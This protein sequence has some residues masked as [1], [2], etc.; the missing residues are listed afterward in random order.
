MKIILRV[1]LFAFLLFSLLLLSKPFLLTNYQ[2]FSY[3]YYAAQASVHHINP[4]APGGLYSG[5]LYPPVCLI[6]LIPF[7]VFPIEIAAKIWTILGIILL[8]ASVSLLLKILGQKVNSNFSIFV[9]SLAFLYFPSRYTL[10]MGQIN[11]FILFFVTIA[12]YF[13][14][15]NKG[16]LSGFFL[17]LSLTIKYFP[18]FILPY[19]FFRKKWRILISL[20]LTLVILTIFGLLFIDQKTNIYFFTKTFPGLLDSNSSTYYYNQALSGFLAREIHD[21]SLRSVSKIVISFIVLIS[22]FFVFYKNKN[23]KMEYILFEIG[24]IVNIS[25]LLNSFSWQH[26]YIWL[27]IPLIMTTIFIKEHKLSYW[28]YVIL[29]VVFLLTS[30]NINNPRNVPLI[31]QSHAFY[32]GIVLLLFDLYILNKI[33]LQKKSKN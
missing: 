12:L 16:N 24:I 15:R 28:N 26:H 21:P 18:L 22:S 32:G 8:V 33:K 19:L 27:L 3:Y 25:V 14:T 1:A 2:D 17:G 29:A 10:G 13:Y 9:F 31:F 7:Q 4:Y 6:F 5:Y 11:M 23:P 20:I 30:Y